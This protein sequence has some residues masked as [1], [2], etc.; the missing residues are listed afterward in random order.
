MTHRTEGRQSPEG[1][2]NTATG[3]VDEMALILGIEDLV[4]SQPPED[5]RILFENPSVGPTLRNLFERVH[6][7]PP[8]PGHSVHPGS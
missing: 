2:D 8:I 7:F 3:E 6:G 5:D 4:A 1:E